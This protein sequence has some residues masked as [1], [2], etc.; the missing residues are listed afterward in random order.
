[1]REFQDCLFIS[2]FPGLGIIITS[3]STLTLF[4]PCL[5]S[6]YCSVFLELSQTNA[7]I[8]L[9]FSLS[10]KY[11]LVSAAIPSIRFENSLLVPSYMNLTSIINFKEGIPKSYLG[12]FCP[13]EGKFSSDIK[14][15]KIGA[16]ITHSRS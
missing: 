2:I 14:S 13:N 5:N 12:C 10:D 16:S 8:E 1:M 9:Y 4:K 3:E 6:E 11:K 15:G 7:I